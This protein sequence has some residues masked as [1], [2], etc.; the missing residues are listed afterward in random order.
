MKKILKLLASILIIVIVFLGGFIV[1]SKINKNSKNGQTIFQEN[2][3][4]DVI[5]NKMTDTE[6]CEIVSNDNTE[7]NTT[8]SNEVA[9]VKIKE[10]TNKVNDNHN[11]IVKNV[12]NNV[13]VIDPGHQAKGDNSKEPIGPGASQTKAKVTTGATGVATGQT[14]SELNLKVAQKLQ[15]AL[16]QKGY[17]VIMTRTTQ[18]VNMSNSERAKIANDANAGAF[19]RIHANAADSS[20]VK[21]VLTMCQTSNN[22]YNGNIA[23]KSYALSRAIVD[24]I[25]TKTGTQ[26]RGVTRT[27]EM[28]GINWCTVPTTIIEMGFLSNPEEDK[29]M[30]TESYQEKIVEGI[31]EGIEQYLNN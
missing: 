30:Y 18:N 9:D 16:E 4:V 3:V 12:N 7:I 17:T 28:S 23:S 2:N 10:D 11:N 1:Y 20:S 26:N 5:E 8:K 31:V 19:I 13:I 25:A 15:A 24:K 6:K 14:E 27:D 22:P 21:G 29:N